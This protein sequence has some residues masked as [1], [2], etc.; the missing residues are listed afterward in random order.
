MS[1]VDHKFVNGGWVNSN[2]RFLS[3]CQTNI[4][5]VIYHVIRCNRKIACSKVSIYPW[6]RRH[7]LFIAAA[8]FNR[9]I[10]SVC[11]FVHPFVYQCRQGWL[12]KLPTKRLKMRLYGIS[13][14]R[15]LQISDDRLHQSA[16]TALID[17]GMNK[18]TDRTNF[19]FKNCGCNSICNSIGTES[20]ETVPHP[21][22]QLC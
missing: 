3:F 1:S 2:E 17:K 7:V 20:L 21:Y 9:K 11:L 12:M 18:Q 15:L 8:I 4:C 10:G 5:C 22:I 16:L 6:D 19:T 14:L 13:F